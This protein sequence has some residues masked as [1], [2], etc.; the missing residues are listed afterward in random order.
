MR[1]ISSRTAQVP[2]LPTCPQLATTATHN[3]ILA[4]TF[5]LGELVTELGG[6]LEHKM[7][8]AKISEDAGMS[9]D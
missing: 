3:E 1:L 9:S 6:E 7:L 8:E 4:Q 5:Y 2:G